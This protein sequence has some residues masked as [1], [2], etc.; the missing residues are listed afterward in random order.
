MRPRV[1]WMTGNDDSILELLHEKNIALPPR[2]LEVNLSREGVNV[3]RRTIQRRLNSLQEAKLVE[4]VEE[5]GSYYA[6]TDKG[7]AYLDGELDASEL[8]NVDD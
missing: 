2:G 3:S 4:M 6:I 8:E 7:R 1:E 5:E